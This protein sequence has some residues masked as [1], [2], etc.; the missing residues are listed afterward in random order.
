MSVRIAPSILSADFAHLADAVA[1][2]EAGGADLIHVDVM[3]GHFVPNITIGPPVVAALKRVDQAAARRAPDDRRTRPVPRRVR[4]RRRDDAHG[5]RRGAAAPA[6]HA[7]AHPR[8]SARGRASRSTR[9]RRSTAIGDVTSRARSPARDVGE[10]RLRRP[11]VHSAQPRE[12]RGGARRC[13]RRAGSQADI[14]V[15]GG[16]DDGNAAALVRAGASILV[17]GASIFGTPRPGR[18]RRARCAAPPTT[19][20]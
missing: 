6:S 8:S 14:E 2:V 5:A 16:V 13:C 3:D 12:G 4:R 15:D 20:A 18:G 10:S 9:R 1:Q 11:V 19:A 7:D 17:A